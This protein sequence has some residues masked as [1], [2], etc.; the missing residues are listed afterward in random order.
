MVNTVRAGSHG[1]LM[2]DIKRAALADGFDVTIAH[3]RGPGDEGSIR[4]GGTA[5]ARAGRRRRL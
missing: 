1:R 5:E 4:I 2:T 3:G